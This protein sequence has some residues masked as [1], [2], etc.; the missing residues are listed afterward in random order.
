MFIQSL[1]LTS[2][3]ASAPLQGQPSVAQFKE[4][5]NAR[6][7]KLKP[8]GT[9]VRTVLFE[10]AQA[11]T[12]NGPIYPFEVTLSIHDYGTGYPPNGYFG[13]TCV[14]KMDKWKF[15]MLRD[16]FGNWN[17]Q[18][19]MTITGAQ[20]K[21]NPS[22]GVSSIPLAT[23][24][25]TPAGNEPATAARPTTPPAAASQKIY[26]GE[27]AC[28]GAGNRLMAGAGFIL[29]A[30]NSYEDVDGKRGG[31]YQYDAGAAT[32]SFRGGFMDGQVGR[33]VRPTGF[34]LSA[35]VSCEPWR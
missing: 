22:Q 5:L 19:R 6:L 12:P 17:V 14:G 20:C 35:T 9:S 8:E 33:N 25:G 2:M 29:K 24:T 15:D 21:N 16:D 31:T 3:L 7:Q 28:Y 4:V 13:Q 26:I 11:G 30:G 27:Y 18:G 32:I 23:L 10:A 1:L 34:T